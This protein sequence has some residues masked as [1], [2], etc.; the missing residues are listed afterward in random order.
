MAEGKIS[1]DPRVWEMVDMQ[2]DM[3]ASHKKLAEDLRNVIR[4]IDMNIVDPDAMTRDQL[5]ATARAQLR[6]ALL[7]IDQLEGRQ[8]P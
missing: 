5:L 4:L 6:G 7:A 8:E 1:A 3:I 2:R